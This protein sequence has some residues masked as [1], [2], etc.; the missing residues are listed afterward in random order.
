MKMTKQKPQN[1]E[2]LKM[3]NLLTALAVVL[4]GAV[5]GENLIFNGSF[6][7]GTDGFAH[8]RYLRPDT[9]PKK[10]CLTRRTGP[11]FWILLLEWS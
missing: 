7:L 8:E 3:K 6:E 1:K 11:W 4:S 10:T 5:W 9:N 2:D